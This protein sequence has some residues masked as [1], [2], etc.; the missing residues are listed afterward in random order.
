MGAE[1]HLSNLMGVNHSKLLS[2]GNF[3]TKFKVTQQFCK[4]GSRSTLRKNS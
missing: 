4:A 2:L 1:P 3:F